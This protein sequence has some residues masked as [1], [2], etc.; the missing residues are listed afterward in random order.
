[1]S[2]S[3]HSRPACARTVVLGI[4]TL[5]SYSKHATSFGGFV[6]KHLI[7]GSED[8]IGASTVSAR[9]DIFCV[10]RYLSDEGVSFVVT[11]RF[12][13]CPNVHHGCSRSKTP[14]AAIALSYVHCVRCGD[15]M[16]RMGSSHGTTANCIPRFQ[17]CDEAIFVG[18]RR[19]GN[20]GVGGD[21]N[22]QIQR[23]IRF[24]NICM[25]IALE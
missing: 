15:D 20:Y 13:D 8:T 19:L 12:F 23:G 17:F 2:W 5:H 9:A 16:F 22:L 25:S 14:A 10:S 24:R 3:V 6:F 4:H 18:G 7:V 21:D 1:M 11:C